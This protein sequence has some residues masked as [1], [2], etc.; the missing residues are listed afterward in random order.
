MTTP[1]AR[2]LHLI[3]QISSEPWPLTTDERTRWAD[4]VGLPISGTP[5]GDGEQDDDPMFA[6]P[7]HGGRAYWNLNP[8]GGPVHLSL[9]VATLNP[10]E[11]DNLR[12]DAETLRADLDHAWQR[13]D[14]D[15]EGASWRAEW[16]AGTGYV[17]RTVNLTAYIGQTITLTFLSDEDGS[18]VTSFWL[19][20]VSLTV[21]LPLIFS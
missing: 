4:R 18:I 13:I 3:H 20:D 9:I 19:D 21:R 17:Q 5:V 1:A 6:A 10:T 7:S 12:A 8:A 11:F 14:D 15:A 16:H 2:L